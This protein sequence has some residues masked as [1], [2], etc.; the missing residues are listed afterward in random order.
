[1]CK[2]TRLPVVQLQGAVCC[3]SGAKERHCATDNVY[4]YHTVSMQGIVHLCGMEC[5]SID[6]TENLI[7]A[8]PTDGY[9]SEIVK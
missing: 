2:I 8:V 9:T 6:T 4:T 3:R 5:C 1:M 7:V